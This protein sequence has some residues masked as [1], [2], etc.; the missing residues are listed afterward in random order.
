M[1]FGEFEIHILTDGTFRL[2]GGAMFGVV[3]KPLWERK[4]PPDDRNRILLSM[5][6]L[7]IRAAGKWMLVETGAGDKWDAKRRDIFDIQAKNRLPEQLAARG[8]APEDISTVI[9]TH[10]HF[11]HCGWNTRRVEGKMVP[12]FA[13][14]TYYLQR[15][16]L[17]HAREPTDR[18]RASY[19]PDNFEPIAAS[20]QWQLVDGEAEIAPGVELVRMPGHTCDMQCVRL[21]SGGKTAMFWA[22]LVPTTAHLPFPWVMGYDLYP[23]TTLENK[24]KW[25][26]EAAREGWLCLFAHD[27]KTPACYLREREGTFEVEPVVVD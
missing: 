16:E 20:G 23:L 18:D 8:V 22:D 14:A 4:S 2:D 15:G 17:E 10:L 6:I 27:V 5:N 26:P 9:N 1:K 25:L 24:K 7:L 11:D 19:F 3:P 21:R 13:N 12:T